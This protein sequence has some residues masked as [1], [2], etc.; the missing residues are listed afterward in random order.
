MRTASPWWVSA[1]NALGLV[2]IFVGER[3]FA[4]SSGLRLVATLLGAAIFVGTTGLRL[5][6]F[7]GS[8]GARRQ[9]ERTL[10]LSHAGTALALIIYALSTD[11]GHGLLGLEGAD[12]KTV[13][14][15]DTI[16]T[17]VWT[18]LATASLI[19][20][21]MAELSLGAAGR[22][23]IDIQGAGA[24]DEAVEYFRVREL[25]TSGLSVALAAAFLMVTCN[26]A[27]E[28][29]V[30][31]DVS[32]FKTSAPGTATQAVVRSMPQPLRVLLFFPEVNEVREEI[33][34]Y[35]RELG[36]LTGKVNVEEH[37]RFVSAELAKEFK[38]S[39]DG[40]V[41]LIQPEAETPADKDKDK[42]KAE[43]KSTP[44][45]ETLTI[46]TDIAKAR[47]SDL[48]TWDSKINQALMK[49]VREKRVVY[50]TVGHGELNDPGSMG[51]M[52]QQFPEGKATLASQLLSSLNYRVE[53]LGLAQGLGKDVP[54]DATLVIM[55]APRTAL[56]EEEISS[57][58]RYVQ[59]GGSLLIALDP[60]GD[61]EL[62]GLE[63]TLGVHFDKAGIT[64]D[65]QFMAQRGT[66]ADRRLVKTNQFSAHAAVTTLSRGDAQTGILLVNAGS[67]RDHAFEGYEGTKEPKRTYVVRSMPS[68]WP[69]INNDFELTA[70]DEKRDRYNIVAVLEGPNLEELEGSKDKKGFRA[71]VVADGD[72]FSDV[73]LT[74]VPTAA[75]FLADA[76]K[77][78]GGEEVFAGE[79]ITEKD[80]FIQHT[81]GED[82]IWFYLTIIG[83]PILVLGIGL[84]TVFLRRRPARRA[85]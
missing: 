74:H 52:A 17:I 20:L 63:G 85:S 44:K 69:D 45:Y 64:D 40:T 39:K 75:A 14:K 50:L 82:V 79:V 10:L 55:L 23:A 41:I 46:D 53:K 43:E 56:L 42:D 84:A 12:A 77:W 38:V 7:L 62:G 35:F 83:A 54:A 60:I 11:W 6:A 16:L 66:I 9:V 30:R 22:T 5:W 49:V 1:L 80:V 29:N 33:A 48:R 8:R 57:L 18:L 28:R 32:Y 51:P 70:P 68:S 58:Q 3:A 34:G 19:P 81:K 76:F 65:V 31:K 26:V 72:L 73:V 37:D 67:L 27:S 25:A 59:R 78:L 61:A 47:K 13:V 21:L 36:R 2:L 71:M 15:A 4:H 24:D